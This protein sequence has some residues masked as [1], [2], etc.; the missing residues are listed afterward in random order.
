MTIGLGILLI[1]NLTGCPDSSNSP[2]TNPA[3]SITIGNIPATIGTNAT[4]KVY[5]N[6]SDSM[7]DTVPHVA[8]GTKD[9]VPGNFIDGKATVTVNLFYPPVKVGGVDPDPDKHGDPW[10]GE[11]LFFSITIAPATVSSLNDIVARGGMTFNAS[12]QN[13]NWDS[14]SL[15]SVDFGSSSTARTE[16]IYNRIICNDRDNGAGNGDTGIT[17]NP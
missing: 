17:V 9:L 12:K 3:G 5:V 4:Y 13:V 11:G 7:D 15:M 10:S 8:Q 16:A 6:I 14:N 2:S 1:L